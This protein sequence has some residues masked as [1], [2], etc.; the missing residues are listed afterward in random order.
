MYTPDLP[1]KNECTV[2]L[3]YDDANKQVTKHSTVNIPEKIGN[4]TVTAIGDDKQGIVISRDLE[5]DHVETIKLPNTIK[6]I[7]KRALVDMDMPYFSTLY[8]NINNLETVGEDA[9][10]GYTRIT[11][12]YAYDKT[13]KSYYQTNTDLYKFRELVGIDHMKQLILRFSAEQFGV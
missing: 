5:P 1:G 7:H 9:F 4:Y 3:V 11:D 8:V 12:I 2:Q 13:D 6:E 10:G